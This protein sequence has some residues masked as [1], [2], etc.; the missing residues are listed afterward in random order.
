MSWCR[1]RSTKHSAANLPASSY[2]LVQQ[3]ID[4]ALAANLPAS[5]YTLVQQSIEDAIAAKRGAFPGPQRCPAP[6]TASRVG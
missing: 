5:S 4:E 2:T 1:V 6:P 3:S